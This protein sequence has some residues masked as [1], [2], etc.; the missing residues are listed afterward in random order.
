[1]GY[2]QLPGGIDDFSKAIISLWFRVPSSTYTTMSAIP[3]PPPETLADTMG[4]YYPALY[5]ILPLISFGSVETDTV[6]STPIQAS[7]IGIDTFATGLP[8]LVCNL[9]TPVNGAIVSSFGNTGP[10]RP[11][12]FNMRGYSGS[13]FSSNPDDTNC[14]ADVWHHALVS[15]NIGGSQ[16]AD[17]DTAGGTRAYRFASDST[18]TWALDDVSKVN[19]SMNRSGANWSSFGLTNPQSIITNWLV[20]GTGYEGLPGPAPPFVAGDVSTF[21]G[22]YIKSSGNP[23]GIPAD[24]TFVDNI[25]QVEMYRPQMWIGQDLDVSISDNRRFFIGADRRPVAE[26][27]SIAALGTPNIVFKNTRNFK[28]GTN[29]GT[30]GN[31]TPSGTINPFSPGP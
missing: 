26:S 23:I 1:M 13:I 3:P 16:S 8:R 4:D 22:G 29:T 17:Y 28:A 30:A 5:Q 9:Q 20:D 27:V 19:G 31:F 18:F 6:A 10:T 7:F 15:F 12:C 11:G 24:A 14:P 21:S 2:L 25:Y